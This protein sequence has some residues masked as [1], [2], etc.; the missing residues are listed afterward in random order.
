MAVNALIPNHARQSLAP[1][2]LG[3][4][5]KPQFRESLRYDPSGEESREGKVNP[6]SPTKKTVHHPAEDLTTRKSP[7]IADAPATNIPPKTPPIADAPATNIPPKIEAFLNEIAKRNNLPAP[8]LKQLQSALKE[9]KNY[10]PLPQYQNDKQG[11][12]ASQLHFKAVQATAESETLVAPLNPAIEEAIAKLED[13]YFLKLEESA[14]D[15]AP[16]ISQPSTAKIETAPAST[17]APITRQEGLL[18]L[19]QIEELQNGYFLPSAD[20][21]ASHDYK[22][23]QDALN[24][25]QKNFKR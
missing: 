2:K 10:T 14:Q 9:S 6:S 12:T 4:H 7:P 11:K 1:Y 20:H 3:N 19:A 5:N 17:P 8:N 18:S 23:M 22:I 21:E 15:K 24:H 25:Y 13:P 16:S